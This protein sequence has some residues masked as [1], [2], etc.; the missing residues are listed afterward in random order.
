VVRQ[1][2]RCGRARRRAGGRGSPGWGPPPSTR[3]PWS[4]AR[5]SS[6]HCR[7]VPAFH[8]RS[9]ALT[10]MSRFLRLIL[11]MDPAGSWFV[12]VVMPCVCACAGAQEPAASALLRLR[13]LREILPPQ[14][15]E[16][17][18][19]EVLALWCILLPLTILIYNH[20]ISGKFASCMVSSST[21]VFCFRG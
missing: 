6:R 18:V 21:F 10:R 14:R 9:L 8:P 2:S 7:C 1:C 20:K 15:A 11:S 16:A 13:V 12:V 5:A 3:P 17:D 19:S 4:G